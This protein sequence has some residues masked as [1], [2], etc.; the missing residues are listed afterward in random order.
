MTYRGRV[1]NGVIVLED[2]GTLPEGA[3]VIVDV[4]VPLPEPPT[5]EPIPSLYERL[6]NVVGRVHDLP[7]DFAEH[8]DHYIHG[9][10]KE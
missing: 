7:P 8:H 5:T 10:P 9:T 1:K 6:K 3:E 4:V 2:A